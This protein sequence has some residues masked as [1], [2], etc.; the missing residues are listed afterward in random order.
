MTRRRLRSTGLARRFL[1]IDTG[2][3]IMFSTA[4]QRFLIFNP[5]PIS[6]IP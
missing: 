6:I 1:E 5:T 3:N 2:T 4:F